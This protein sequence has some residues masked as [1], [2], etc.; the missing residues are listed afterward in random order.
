MPQASAEMQQQLAL[1]S[2]EDGK[3]SGS[4]KD[5]FDPHPACSEAARMARLRRVC[6]KKPS[7]KLHV[8]EEIHQKWL[9]NSGKDREEL[10][11]ALKQC[12][13]DKDCSLRY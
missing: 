1:A 11:D 5:K 9:A 13:W 3:A 4:S 7:G 10:L 12:N 2:G 8:P 6:E